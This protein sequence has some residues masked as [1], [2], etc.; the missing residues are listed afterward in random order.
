MKGM[1][2]LLVAS[3]LAAFGCAQ[4]PTQDTA[5][6][7]VQLSKAA[8]PDLPQG[9][10]GWKQGMSDAQASLDAARRTPRR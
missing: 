4:S 5:G 10:P 8:N 7:K 6:A 9:V 1:N 3:C 2:Y